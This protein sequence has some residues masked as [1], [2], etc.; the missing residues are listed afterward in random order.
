MPAHVKDRKAINKSRPE[1]RKKVAQKTR[2]FLRMTDAVIGRV[3]ESDCC[4]L[5]VRTSQ[6]GKQRFIDADPYPDRWHFLSTIRRMAGDVAEQIVA[7][8]QRKGDL[9]GVGM[10]ITADEGAQDPWTLPP[11]QAQ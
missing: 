7:E 2:K 11:S 6:I 5:T 9:I 10:S 1:D 4:A 8:A 3:R